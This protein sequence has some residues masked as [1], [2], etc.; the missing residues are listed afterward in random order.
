ML[1]YDATNVNIS[2][3]IVHISL[4]LNQCLKTIDIVIVI[5]SKEIETVV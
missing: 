4:V 5:A 1:C 3:N 2:V